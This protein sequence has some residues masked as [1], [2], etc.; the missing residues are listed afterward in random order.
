[1]KKN[2]SIEMRIYELLGVKVFRKMAFKFR[3]MLVFPFFISLPKAERKKL[4]YNTASN[5]NIG[6]VDSL[7][8]VKKF[9]K[10]LFINAG[11][12][13]FGLFVCLPNFLKIVD[14]TAS[15]S[16][17]IVDFSAICINT[18][19]IMLQRYNG[20]RI[21]Q[22]I[23]KMTPKYEKQK[24]LIKEDLKKDVEL[25]VDYTYKITDTKGEKTDI[26][27]ENLIADATIEQLQQYRKYIQ[28]AIQHEKI[29]ANG[30]QQTDISMPIDK[31]KIIK[32]ELKK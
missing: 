1:M 11:I 22:L 30:L 13:I 10:Q 6:R 24:E 17:I 3:D 4:L 9:R 26:T 18:Y 14:G 8:D 29:G 31:H 23:K 32:L 19:C 25:L 21:H 2:E 20:I 15:L 5:Y 28:Q 12:H 7:E 27:F 16:T